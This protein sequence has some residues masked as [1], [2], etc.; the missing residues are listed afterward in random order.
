MYKQ[1]VP[2]NKMA[3]A[4]EI[5][6]IFGSAAC[7]YDAGMGLS[8]FFAVAGIT[9]TT[10]FSNNGKAFKFFVATTVATATSIVIADDIRDWRKNGNWLSKSENSLML[11]QETQRTQLAAHK[12]EFIG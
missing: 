7:Q 9:A 5:A 12:F 10:V 2:T 1:Q 8:A 6:T 4:L 11:P 3:R